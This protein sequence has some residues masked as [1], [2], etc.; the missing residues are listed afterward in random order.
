MMAFSVDI[1][2]AIAARAELVNTADAAALAGVQQL[3]SPYTQWQSASAANKSTI[4]TNA[5]TLAKATVTAV[6]NANYVGGSNVQIVAGDIDV[7]YTNATGKYYSGNQGQIPS[8][9]FPNTVT[10][11]ARRDNTNVANGSNGELGLFFG[12]V[13]GKNASSPESVGEFWLGEVTE[14]VI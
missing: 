12:P 6:A 4:V 14:A 3:Y 5:T 10:V 11:T 7:G 13:V 2:Y 1:G 8:T 9:A